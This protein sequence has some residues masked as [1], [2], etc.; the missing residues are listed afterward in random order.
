MLRSNTKNNRKIKKQ[1]SE[2]SLLTR[3]VVGVLLFLLSCFSFLSLWS[4]DWHDIPALHA[5]SGVVHN[6]VG[7]AGAWGTYAGYMLFGLG[8]WTLPF[9]MLL[10]GFLMIMGKLVHPWRKFFWA[11]LF[12]VSLCSIIEM[13]GFSRLVE[14]LNIR[15][16]GGCFAWLF[17]TKIFV[18]LLGT[19]GS[20]L[21]FLSLIVVTLLFGIGWENWRAFGLFLIDKIENRRIARADAAERATL[22]ELKRLREEAKALKE[23]ERNRLKAE[24]EAEKERIRAEKEAKREARRA[25]KEEKQ[26][27]KEEARLAKE[28]QYELQKERLRLDREAEE[29]RRAEDARRAAEEESQNAESRNAVP[30]SPSRHESPMPSPFSIADSEE[31]API[32][33]VDKPY[34][35][36]S[37]DLLTP[38]LK[39]EADC[40]DTE[41][42]AR[43]ISETLSEFDVPGTITHIETGPVI[44]T[45]E[46][47]PAPRIRP[48]KVASMDLTLAMRIKAKSLRIEAPIPGKGVCGIEVPNKTA[49][50]V[51]VREILDGPTWREKSKKLK[52]PL[53]LGKD[54]SGH[55]LVVDLAEMPHLL[56]AGATGS[57]K[58]V[59][60]NAMLTGLLM[61]RTPDEL[62][63]ILVDPKVVEF[64]GYN[65]IPHLVVPVI[66]E[67]KKVA[68]GLLWAIHEMEK[69]YKMLSA[70][71]VKNI[72]S[73]NN[74]N[75]V[76]VQQ[77][78]FEGMEGGPTPSKTSQYPDKLPYIV[79]VIDEMADLMLQVK[80]EIEDGITRLAQK[81][82]AVGIHLILA[83]QRP[84]VNIVTGTIKANIAGRVAFQVAQKNDSKVILDRMGADSLIGKGDM[85]FL[86][87]RTGM[88]VRAQ[89][90]FITDADAEA[91]TSFIRTQAQPKYDMEAQSQ[92]E[93]AGVSDKGGAAADGASRSQDAGGAPGDG[94][95]ANDG[96]DELYDQ[97]IAVIKRTRRAS[98]SSLQ[99]ALAIGYNR[100]ARIFDQL[101]ERGIVGPSRGALPRE[102][103]IDLDGEIPTNSGN[104]P[105]A[106]S[107][108]G[109]EQVSEDASDDI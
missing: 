30:I 36:P 35:L 40:G 77:D 14:A 4:Y 17:A 105:S 52:L 103:L 46:F 64:T 67:P 15:S 49:R 78:M 1:P 60:M 39:G 8:L 66:T 18:P 24:K 71:G 82:R 29:N 21:F 72:E 109:E 69:R 104:D 94:V 70:V 41:E 37:I 79:I 108:E 26:R 95:A 5:T 62:K 23:E 33:P 63:L 27:L 81:S 61:S 32:I 13:V 80:K 38:M 97:A 86:N 3:L 56:V 20:V 11:L 6:L 92:L 68:L 28:Q 19:V 55:D 84:T 85:L 51:T 74:R 65:S 44:T 91:V 9:W 73:F 12:L 98:T 100:A 59:C 47:Q 87:P 53:L 31:K 7:M 45:Y 22:E 2:P 43:L 96:T 106:L 93:A 48:E 102:I 75:K 58:S 107:E 34:E 42:T 25:E 54:A 83:T 90:A 99:R 16:S 101:E 10:F 88:T 89:G 57:G 76:A 50:S